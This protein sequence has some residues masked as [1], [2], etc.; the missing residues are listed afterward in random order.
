MDQ[1]EVTAHFDQDGNI[2]PIRFYWQGEDYPVASSGRTWQDKSGQHFL[3]M[4][5]DDRVFELVYKLDN[6]R[7][8]LNL[9]GQ[10]R[11]TA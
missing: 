7:W 2:R 3:V 1:I 8:F 10:T 6:N 11:K 9:P 5:P 4:L